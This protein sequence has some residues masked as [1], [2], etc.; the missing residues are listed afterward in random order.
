MAGLIMGKLSASRLLEPG[1][2]RRV[3]ME[4][5][6][7]EQIRSILGKATRLSLNL[8][9]GRDQH[10]LAPTRL[11]CLQRLDKEQDVC[12][13]YRNTGHKSWDS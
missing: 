3:G 6:E 13:R 1:T 10:R 4:A 9:L 8:R 12:L 7:L 5:K 2:H 11:P